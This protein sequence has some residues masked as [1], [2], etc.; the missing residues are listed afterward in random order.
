MK[1]LDGYFKISKCYR[2]LI[3]LQV[4]NSGAEG[5]NCSF[6]I[7]VGIWSDKEKQK[8]NH[9]VI[10]VS[11]NYCWTGMDEK[12]SRKENAHHWTDRKMKLW[13]GTMS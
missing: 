6:S 4:D 11:S 9:Q 8:L 13:T 2:F 12:H 3:W 1:K 7:H 5:N 10:K